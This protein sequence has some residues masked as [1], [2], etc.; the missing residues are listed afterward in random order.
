MSSPVDKETGEH[1]KGI[2]MVGLDLVI[3]LG[4]VF[5]PIS[6]LKRIRDTGLVAA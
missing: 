3:A 2:V 1:G 5:N 6:G 4:L